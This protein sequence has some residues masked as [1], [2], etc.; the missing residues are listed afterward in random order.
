MLH[1]LFSQGQSYWNNNTH[2]IPWRL[3]LAFGKNTN[4]YEDL[5]KD[6]K[7][8]IIRTTVHDTIPI[9]W[10]DDDGDMEYGDYEGDTDNDCLLADLNGDGIFGGPEDLCIDWIDT[11]DDGIADMQFVIRNGKKEVRYTPDYEADFICVIDREKD[12][13]QTFIDWNKLLPQCWERNG[14]ADFFQDYHGNTLLLK[15]HNSSFSVS[16]PRMSCE[17]PFI[18]LD[19]DS[20]SLTEMNIR[21]MDVPYLRPRPEQKPDKRFENLSEEIDIIPSGQITWTAISWDMDNDNGQGNEFDFDMTLHFGGKGFDYT[22]QIHPFKNTRKTPEADSLLY[23]ARWRQITE[24]IYP[25]EKAAYDLIFSKGDWQYCW[26][27]FDEDDD[28]NR[29]ERVELYYP[30]DIFKIGAGKGG[31][32][33]HKQSDAIGDRGEFD[34]DNSGKGKLYISPVDGRIHL[35]GAEWG[36]WRIDQNAAYFQGYGGLYNNRHPE[37]RLYEEPNSWATVKYSDTDNNGFFDLVEYDLDGDTVFEERTNLLD[38]GIDDKAPLFDPATMS[39]EDMRKLFSA[40]VENIWERAQKAIETSEKRK[41]NTSWYAFWKHPRTLFEKYAY[42]Y[43]LNFYISNDLKSLSRNILPEKIDL[44]G[45]WNVQTD[46]LNSRIHLPGSLSENK[47]GIA[48]TDSVTDRLSEQYRFEG[49]AVYE[50]NI[51]IPASWEGKTVELFIERTK[52]SE[53]WVNDYRIGSQNSV[54]TPHSYLL[55]NIFK[56]GENK[57]TITIDN[58]R[59]LLPLGGS[60]AFSEHTQTNWNGILGDFYLKCLEGA[61]IR[62]I[63]VYPRL[64]GICQLKISTLNTNPYTKENQFLRI[65]VLDADRKEVLSKDSLIN[66]LPGTSGHLISLHLPS[67][68]KWDEYNPYLY[69]L[70]V[71]LPPGGRKE[72]RFGFREFKTQAGQF[73]NN[74]RIVFLRG[75][76]EGGVFPLT[77]YP[78]MKKEDWKHYFQVLKSYKL[79]HVRFHSWTPPSAA[80]EAADE[81]GVFLQP[82]LPLWGSYTV[83]DTTLFNYM[84]AEGEYILQSYG[85][86]PSFVMFALGNELAGDT[87]LMVEMV[88]HL[89]LKDNR[90]LY[91]MGSNNFYWD[92]K[93]HNVED[94][95]VA[96]RNGKE[97][98]GNTMDL[99]GSFSFADSD[100]GGII[101]NLK[102]D[103]ERNF[104]QA[105]ANLGKPVIGHET[106][107]Y[108]VYPDFTELEKY[109][110]VLQA[111]NFAV[112]RNRLEKAGML[113]QANDFLKASGALSALCYKEEIE[114]ALRTPHFGG[115]Q[116]LDLKDYPGQGTALVGILNVFLQPKGIISPEKWTTFCN[117]IV[118]LASFPKYCLTPAETFDVVIRIANYGKSDMKNQTVSCSL[119]TAGGISFF[120]KNIKGINLK[121][122]E[123]T[124]AGDL[125]IALKEIVQ[126]QKLTFSVQLQGTDIKNTWNIWVYPAGSAETVRE[127]IVQGVIITRNR[128]IFKLAST[129]QEPVLYIPEHRDITGQSVGGLFTTDFWNYTVFKKIA[130]NLKK[131]PSPGTLGILTNPEHPVFNGFPTDFHTDWQWWN[132]VKNSRPMILDNMPDDYFPIVQVIDNVDRNHKL[133]L[134]YELPG[135]KGKA[136]VCTSD[137]FACKE[138]PEVKALFTSLLNY[139]KN[140]NNNHDK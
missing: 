68:E 135:T 49:K 45:Y 137:L 60:H 10:I 30:Y 93:T 83:N 29:W 104:V 24:L 140:T 51:K 116:L 47:I 66:I 79:N 87:A 98:G 14:H 97:T 127:G 19:P 130:E 31:Q 80:F 102:P 17:N 125:H 129:Q 126:P 58:T 71:D 124:F 119:K 52:V 26:F 39:Y 5:N 22:G 63:Q 85:N 36:V 81:A 78:G 128:E 44:S 62:N 121:Q 1:A 28:C 35:F 38:E 4:S 40:S 132:I 117:D 82:E 7:P 75:T 41:L 110:G 84:K 56:Q 25:D 96:M 69:S 54:S 107:Q 13:I 122:G 115:F 123:I 89:K 11:D 2:L 99:R 73:V 59:K 61:D 37:K 48:V 109:T 43:W 72:I 92:T 86:H 18:F 8:D 105:A 100:G 91:A 9:L 21:L 42:G 20:D 6:G 70:I 65:R 27:V 33:T 32:D 77:G 34:N 112:F 94:F 74:N 67:P 114:M 111:R 12:G 138:E 106:G 113:P 57:L 133:G 16:D 23:D 136:L 139:L 118:P 88:N 131:T 134:I 64:D 55:K 53:V 95:F 108:Q 101:N 90:R 120:E 15:M 103:T 3:P 76:H 50:R 46:G